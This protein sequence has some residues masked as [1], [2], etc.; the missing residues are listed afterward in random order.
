[1]ATLAFAIFLGTEPR[2]G[3][4]TGAGQAA[5]LFWVASSLGI[6]YL[7]SQ[8]SLTLLLVDG[9]YHTARFTLYGMIQGLWL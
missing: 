6:N 8:P 7:P 2:F 9:G 1:M 4:A 5:G 3:F